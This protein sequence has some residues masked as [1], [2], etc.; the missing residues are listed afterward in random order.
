MITQKKYINKVEH[1]WYDSSNLV[2]TACYDGER[3]E[4]TLKVVFKG[5]RT[6]I[7]KDVDVNDY[8]LFT[9]TASSNGEAFNKNIVKKYKGVRV[10]DTDLSQ[11]E[12]MRKEYADENKKIENALSPL[13]YTLQL[14]DK[15]GEFRL[16]LDG[17]T[18]YEGVE[19]QVSIV[20]LFNSMHI[21]YGTTELEDNL[22]T[23]QDFID[24]VEKLE[25]INNNKE[26]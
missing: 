20:N 5:G 14:N 3:Q 17:K 18:I 8:V 23:E 10:S 9:R 16:I 11:L 6:Y 15:T 26:E 19:G 21:D 4:K 7:Y 22:S 2:Y 13:S 25:P 1:L 12:E 24:N